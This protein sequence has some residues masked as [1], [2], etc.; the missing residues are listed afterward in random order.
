[1]VI[2]LFKKGFIFLYLLVSLAVVYALCNGVLFQLVISEPL[3]LYSIL[4]FLLSYIFLLISVFK[5]KVL[6]P[7]SLLL[8]LFLIGPIIGPLSYRQFLEAHGD[9]FGR[10]AIS[11]A[12]PTFVW[13]VGTTLFFAGTLVS[14]LT[15]RGTNPDYIVLWDFK[16]IKFFLWLT[17]GVA[18]FCTIFA[19][20]KIGYIPIISGDILDKRDEYAG[21]V[22]HYIF[23]FSSIWCIAGILS[24]MLFFLTNY[25]RIYLFSTIICAVGMMFYG[26]RRPGLVVIISFMLFYFKFHRPK[27]THWFIIVSTVIILFFAA[28]YLGEIRAGRDP[29]K[30][31]ISELVFQ[32]FFTEWY[33]GAIVINETNSK[34]DYLGSKIFLGQFATLVPR[35]FYW[36]FGHNKEQII[37]KYTAAYYYGQMFNDEYGIRIT[38]IGEA[39]AG[40]G[41]SGVVW[42][43]FAFGLCLGALDKFY[44]KLKRT[45]ARLCFVN[46]MLS[47]M[48]YLPIGMIYMILTPIVTQGIFLILYQL[49]GAKKFSFFSEEDERKFA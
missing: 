5:T 32:G 42:Q 34:S 37:K 28:I 17:F 13:A 24:S 25:R 49:Y 16:R 29:T 41:M 12:Q 26:Q 46:Y 18:F 22:G 7:S 45:D 15:I 14:H 35:Q 44:L 9:F 19:M 38:P 4:L 33:Y 48:F 47:L 23:R 6:P 40:Y 8:P 39:Y 1:M 20:I 30:E 11:F 3:Y 10:G 2:S 31:S 21:I 27:M 36:V 43:L